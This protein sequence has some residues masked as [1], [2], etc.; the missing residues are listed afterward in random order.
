MPCKFDCIK[1][2]DAYFYNFLF[3]NLFNETRLSILTAIQVYSQ[4][5]FQFSENFLRI[6][7]P[8]AK[9]MSTSK[10]I[11]PQVTPQVKEL[12]KVFKEVHSRSELQEQLLLTD[13]ENFRKVYLLPAIEAGLIGLTI[14]DKPTSSNQK[15]YLTK[16]GKQL[17]SKLKQ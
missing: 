7:L 10:I 15:Y 4:N 5:C 16:K 2:R 17:A 1:Q 13:R 3:C 6:T 12:L 8:S 11:T 9:R 14:P